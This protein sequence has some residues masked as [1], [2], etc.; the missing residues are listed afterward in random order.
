MI[1]K[2]ICIKINSFYQDTGF[3]KILGSRI[4]KENMEDF[5]LVISS[6]FIKTTYLFLHLLKWKVRII[7]P[8]IYIAP[9]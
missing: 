3:S 4:T 1:E 8:S 5:N 7:V 9:V 6:F 2:G